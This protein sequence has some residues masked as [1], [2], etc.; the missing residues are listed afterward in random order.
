ME[1]CNHGGAPASLGGRPPAGGGGVAR[2]RS[3][4]VG[5]WVTYCGSDPTC[6]TLKAMA[7]FHGV[8]IVRY[9]V[10]GKFLWQKEI[11]SQD[12][13]PPSVVGLETGEIFVSSPTDHDFGCGLANANLAK[14]DD[15]GNCVWAKHFLGAVPEF[16]MNASAAGETF[17]AT[18][19]KDPVDFGC[20]LLPSADEGNLAI[21][22]LDVSGNCVFSKAFTGPGFALAYAGHGYPHA[23]PAG[24][25]QWLVSLPFEGSIDLGS[26]PISASDVPEGDMLFIKI[27]ASGNPVWSRRLLIPPYEGT[28]RRPEI[29]GEPS[30]GMILASNN[31]LLDLGCGPTLNGNAGLYLAKLAP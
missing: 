19:F 8:A 16:T 31:P 27:D 2:V 30:G 15:T 13:P 25:D 29:S 7:I 26:G 14:L 21:T 22:K 28:I 6:L 10:T 4:A 5:G 11:A 9:D 24:G 12:Y 18:V 23:Y 3:Y 17:I 1:E 20:G